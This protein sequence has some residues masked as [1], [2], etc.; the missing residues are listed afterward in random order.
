VNRQARTEPGFNHWKSAAGRTTGQWAELEFPVPVLVRGVRLHG[1]RD[2]VT[3]SGTSVHLYADLARSTRV[4]SATSGP[5]AEGGTDVAFPDARARVVRV[6]FTS[7]QGPHTSLAEIEVIAAGLGDVTPLVNPPENLQVASVAGTTVRLQWTPPA[8]PAPDGYVLEGGLAPGE[9]IATVPTGALPVLELAPSAGRY[10]VRVRGNVGGALSAPSNEVQI[11]PGL[12]D[13]PSPP[14]SLVG[15]ADGDT[16]HLAWR[17]TFEG[18]PVSAIGVYANGHL[19]T[20]LS[21][22]VERFSYRGVPAGAYTIAVR[23]LGAG[24]TT[25]D[26]SNSITLT[27]PGSCTGGP[28]PPQGLT[29]Y[30]DGPRVIVRWDPPASGAA[31]T[32]YVLEVSGSYTGAFPL[33]ERQAA[34]VLGP[35]SYT[36][37]VRAVNSCG[38][39][40]PS[41]AQTV[42]IP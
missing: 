20:T 37:R 28:L 30:R 29:V 39:S 42:T 17:N 7:V 25:S 40:P 5:V 33:A 23:A 34:G 41:T 14:D 18:G 1:P 38:S 10:Y 19:A 31:H 15:L 16:V 22:A 11:R 8:G 2:G 21:G 24:G 13:P 36:L 26:A 35:G 32:G 27:F 3:V 9:T 6:E 12:A 4:A